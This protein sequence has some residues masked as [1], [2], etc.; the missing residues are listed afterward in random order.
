MLIQQI[1][2]QFNVTDPFIELSFYH[3]QVNFCKFFIVIL[4]I[5]YPF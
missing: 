2:R 3:G 5:K 4:T 1:M